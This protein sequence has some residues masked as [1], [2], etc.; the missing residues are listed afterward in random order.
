MFLTMRYGYGYGYGYGYLY[1]LIFMLPA[2]ILGL[3]AQLK[4]KGTFSKYNK[5]QNSR[6]M[7]GAQMARMVLDRN[8]LTYVRIEPIQGDLTDHYDPRDNVIRLSA[9]VYNSTSIGAIGV[10]AH[11][12]GHAIQH[13]EEYTPIRLRNAILPVCNFG[14]GFGPFLIVIGC[15]FAENI[16]GQ[17]LIFFGILLFSLVALFQLVTLP[18]EFDASGRALSVIRD[19]GLFQNED[20]KGAKKV[21][22]AAALTYVAALITT[23]MQILY[24]MTRILGNGKR[25]D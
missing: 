10:A 23:I 9:P 16:F 22:K 13:A 15:L 14:S 12:A 25:R 1:Y 8:G 20:Y 18:V 7:T 5:I 6:G 17:S 3:Y 21:L 19:S 2:L 24:Y 11:E 4:V